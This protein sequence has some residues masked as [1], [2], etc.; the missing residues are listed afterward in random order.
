MMWNWVGYSKI[1]PIDVYEFYDG[2]V[3]IDKLE[4]NLN[5]NDKTD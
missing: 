5:D 2:K 4:S 1:K 3:I